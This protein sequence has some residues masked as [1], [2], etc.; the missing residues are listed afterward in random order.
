[1]KE[2]PG[3]LLQEHQF[4]LKIKAK[5][6]QFLEDVS[7]IIVIVQL[8]KNHGLENK[9]SNFGV[10]VLKQNNLYLRRW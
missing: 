8:V 6:Y 5:M 2:I 10:F 9:V 3:L 1:M 7:L 4:H